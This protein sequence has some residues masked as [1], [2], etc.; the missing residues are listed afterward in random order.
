M[1]FINRQKELKD[2]NT[3]W[4][5]K[6]ANFLVIY[7]KRRV[8]KTELIK[9]FLK[10]KPGIYY[11]A[12]KRRDNDQL[13]ELGQICGTY[14]KDDILLNHGFKDWLEFFKYIKNKSITKPFVLAIDE[15]PYLTENNKELS[16]LLQKA[17]DNYLKDT[18]IFLIL[19][20]S[21]I[22]MMEKETLA[23]R[24]PLFGR[25]TGQLLIE[26][27]NFFQSWQ[28]FPNKNFNDFLQIYTIAGGMPAYLKQFISSEK[29]EIIVK[30]KILNTSSFLY[31]ELEF[32]LKE[33]LRE[34]KNYLA[35][36]K[37]ISEG[38][39]KLGKISDQ[40]GLDRNVLNKY[41]S[42]LLNLKI[43]E[44]QLPVTEKYPLKSR[45]GLYKIT[46]NFTIFWFYFIF[47]FKSYLSLEKYSFV[48][49]KIFGSD[50]YS[51]SQNSKFKLLL[52]NTYEQVSKEI[53][54]NLQNKIFEFEKIDSWWLNEEEID[55]VAINER[56]K[57]IL[58]GECKWTE[59]LLSTKVYLNLKRKARLVNWHN[60]TRKEYFILFSKSGFT[61]NLIKIA[62]QEN[63]LLVKKNK[64]I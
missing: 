50:N 15:Y 57:K 58:F 63:V 53:L 9:Q 47:P 16:S 22:A 30:N 5:K 25:R 61:K 2:L 59:K 4:K 48:L 52:S 44:R 14:F 27:L 21:S 35:I 13:L 11:L 54:G 60:N 18:K 24:S 1:E 23:L 62:K 56:S 41:L 55:I 20:G 3:A 39:R 51:D 10:D 36:L 26:P 40:L 6:E 8:G 12:D 17:W 34:P 19:C 49:N 7:G 64:L 31:N 29:L 33:E 32:M 28:F 46:D 45:K 38:Q 37:A 43:I 42:V